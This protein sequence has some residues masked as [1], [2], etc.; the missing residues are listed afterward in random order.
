MNKLL[1]I[2]L[3]LIVFLRLFTFFCKSSFVSAKNDVMNI[4]LFYGQGCRHMTMLEKPLEFNNLVQRFLSEIE[5][6]I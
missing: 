3:K 1:K 4:Y 2:T 6:N 5:K